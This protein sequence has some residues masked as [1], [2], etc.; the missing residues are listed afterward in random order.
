MTT[1]SKVRIFKKKTYTSLRLTNL[2]FTELVTICEGVANAYCRHAM[3]KEL[4]A[5]SNNDTWSLIPSSLDMNI[6]GNR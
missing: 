2:D 4:H 1:Q 6:I 3:E 5:L